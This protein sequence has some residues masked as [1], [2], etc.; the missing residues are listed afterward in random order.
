MA[1]FSCVRT[2]PW[3]P[4][5]QS[6]M[7]AP[8]R[9]TRFS[10][11][12]PASKRTEGV[13]DADAANQVSLPVVQR[14]LDTLY[15]FAGIL[16]AEGK[17]LEINRAALLVSGVKMEDVMGI[18]FHLAY[19][20]SH[21]D[22][23][24][25]KILDSVRRAQAGETVRFD[26]D[27]R[28]GEGRFLMIDYMIVPLR[29]AQ[30]RVTHL[31]PSAID[32]TDRLR[33]L[34]ER[35]AL[36]RNLHEVNALLDTII[37]AAPI[38][39]GFWDKELRFQRLN[40]ALAEINGLPKEAH[41]GRAIHDL[42]PDVGP[43]SAEQFRQVLETGEPVITEVS[44]MTP[45]QP[46]VLRTWHVHY[47]P[48][49]IGGETVGLGAICEEIT[50]RKRAQQDIETLNAEL[51]RKVEERTM[52]L[53]QAFRREQ[54]HRQRLGSIVT[55]LPQAALV[56]DEHD[57]VLQANAHLCHV[58][59]IP[60][61]PQELVGLSREE[62]LEW[63]RPIL[64]AIPG[65]W[66]DV[67]RMRRERQTIIGERVELQ[68]GRVLLR[69]F[70]PMQTDGRPIGQMFLYR[71]ITEE[72]RADTAKS[73]FMAL[74]SHQLRTPLTALRWMIGR[75]TRSL[76][77]RLTQ[78]EQRM[79]QEGKRAA[80]R[81]ADTIDTM[82]KISRLE[83]GRVTSNVFD[84]P[85]QGF[86]RTCVDAFG[87]QI[88]ERRLRVSVDCTPDVWL[89]TDPNFLQEIIANLIGNAIKYTPPLGR[90]SVRAAQSPEVVTLEVEDT[91]MGIPLHQQEKVFRK[92]FRGENVVSQETDGNGLGLYLVWL[93]TTMLGGTVSF[94]SEE[95][96]GST[97]TLRFPTPK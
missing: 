1:R 37:D 42:L 63:M 28:I 24:R 49:R 62:I 83:S 25:Q 16:D 11:L 54:E 96:K 68:D 34:G 13:P 80:G 22:E 46:G 78:Q 93:M 64:P 75:L 6:P 79:L 44:G 55:N 18:P 19:W 84:I 71:D 32:L 57:R 87:D 52:G 86:L 58:F 10:W 60:R 40:D 45:A 17:I 50:Q 15:T 39:I 66:E 76:G 41:M 88:E 81:M 3:I 69:D 36:L 4:P 95:G 33:A 31:I 12:L 9:G 20:W 29:D 56:L 26:V 51:E 74:A 53:E 82:L 92:F 48:V 67:D 77:P 27:A 35:D 72:N 38:G 90:V 85:L 73:E 70:I 65:F 2:L 21:S 8:S 61:L 97:F 7:A 47:Y 94:Q 91:G 23:V 5:R 30:G 43:A 89:K 59:R 14:V